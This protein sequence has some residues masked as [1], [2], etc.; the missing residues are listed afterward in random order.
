[1]WSDLCIPSHYISRNGGYL[2]SPPHAK[3]LLVE[4]PQYSELPEKLF[5]LG[6]DLR[7]TGTN[8]RVT[9]QGFVPVVCYSST[10]PL[11]K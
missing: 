8:T 9:A 5:D 2:I 4:V 10:I 1:M 11:E 6:Y 7:L 3:R